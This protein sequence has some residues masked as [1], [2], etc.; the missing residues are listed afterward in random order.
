MPLSREEAW[1]IVGL[2][3]R[4]KSRKSLPKND[5]EEDEEEVEKM[6]NEVED[7]K[8]DGII[9]AFNGRVDKELSE[10]AGNG[11]VRLSTRR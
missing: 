6:E 7:S 10:F 3:D 4:I 8:I 5:D 9:D 2:A 1:A 11:F